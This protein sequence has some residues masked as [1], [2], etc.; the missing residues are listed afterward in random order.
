MSALP[1]A[2]TNKKK[3]I[4]VTSTAESSC[5]LEQ[6]A[7]TP[8]QAT[9]KNKW[10]VRAMCTFHVD[11][12]DFWRHSQKVTEGLQETCAKLQRP[13][14]ASLHFIT[15]WSRFAPAFS[16][17]RCEFPSLSSP[18]P[19]VSSQR[20]KSCWRAPCTDAGATLL[21][22]SPRVPDVTPGSSQSTFDSRLLCSACLTCVPLGSPA[23]SV[24]VFNVQPQQ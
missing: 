16:T 8:D 14:L 1:A 6:E 10:D 4:C 13:E 11:T 20:P 17:V 3:L 18:M 22:M 15:L 12:L 2:R 19:T 5:G 9:K 23:L 24:F 21:P 7:T